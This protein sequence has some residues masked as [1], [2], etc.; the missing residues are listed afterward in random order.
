MRKESHLHRGEPVDP[1]VLVRFQQLEDPCLLRATV[2]DAHE[3]ALEPSGWRGRVAVEPR[4][5]GSAE[6]VVERVVER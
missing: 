5:P 3:A 4:Q 2:A 6:E 1:R